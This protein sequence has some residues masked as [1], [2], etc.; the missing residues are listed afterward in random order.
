MKTYY[1]VDADNQ[2]AGPIAPEQFKQYGVGMDTLVWTKDMAEWT[3]A[4]LIPELAQIIMPPPEVPD[5]EEEPVPPPIPNQNGKNFG[6]KPER[7]PLP[8]N[9]IANYFTG[10]LPHGGRIFITDEQI[11]FKTNV[12]NIPFEQVIQVKDITGYQRGLLNIL[13]IFAGNIH[14]KLG[15]WKKTQIINEIENRRQAWFT[16]RGMQP[17]LLTRV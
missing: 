11:T 13:H 17:P 3:K 12:I 10:P 6:Q 2:K 16:S 7:E 1:Y 4:G 8:L 9:F 5:S 14:W 15:V